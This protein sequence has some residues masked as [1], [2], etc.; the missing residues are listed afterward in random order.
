VASK[1]WI[2][3]LPPFLTGGASSQ[4][5]YSTRSCHSALFMINIY[6][7]KY[8]YFCV[9][10]PYCTHQE[11]T[12]F[13]ICEELDASQQIYSTRS[14]TA[15]QLNACHL[16]VWKVSPPIPQH[17]R[18]YTSKTSRVDWRLTF[19]KVL[20]M[21]GAWVSRATMDLP[22]RLINR[23]TMY[24]ISYNACRGDPG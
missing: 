13:S 10:E 17:L 18:L 21:R 2:R 22:P 20:E 23:H 9:Y 4:R 19:R 8:K 15:I 5:I 12:Y 24:N 14:S 7:H 3:R 16:F 1:L 11:S 6:K